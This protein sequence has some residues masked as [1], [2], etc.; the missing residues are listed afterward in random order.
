MADAPLVLPSLPSPAR[1]PTPPLIFIRHPGYG[2]CNGEDILLELPAV[3]YLVVEPSS[4][5][6]TWGLHHGT[7]IIACGIVA[8]N[9]FD[10]IYF[11]Y[12][13]YGQQRVRTPRDGLLKP[14]DYWLQLTGREPPPDVAADSVAHIS[15]TCSPSPAPGDKCYRYPIVPSFQDW[16]FPHG[17]LPYEWQQPHNPPNPP[18]PTDQVANRC[19]LTD[20]QIGVEE[21]HVIPSAQQKWFI[22]NQMRRYCH[23]SAGMKIDD[24]ANMLSLMAHFRVAFDN[25]LFI[26]IPKPSAGSPSS[27]L[28]LSTTI[29]EPTS[30][31][32]PRPYA[33]ATHFL[34]NIPEACDF[35]NLYHNVSIQTKY[36]NT[37]SREFLFA[38]FAWAL[39][40]CLRGFLLEST[41]CRHLVVSEG[42]KVTN[43]W[44]NSQQYKKHLALR[45]ESV[46]TSKRRRGDLNSQNR[47][48]DGEDNAYEERKRH[49][50]RRE[51]V[52]SNYDWGSS[53][54]GRSIHRDTPS[55][56]DADAD[57]DEDL[58]G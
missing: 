49:S 22:Q 28:S 20:L 43:K 17:K 29:A 46:P 26:I 45:G 21:C 40:S 56:P 23:T 25:H 7:A 15:A 11:S 55:E 58:P 48:S 51:S 42:N 38:R 16:Q 52:L 6:R 10:D 33:F 44:M 18:P 27:S 2:E 13:L 53:D 1:N 54:R 5:V 32:E 57:T 19:F 50:A 3:D 39:F 24:K 41:V 9:T 4:Q 36:I 35:A 31:A 12:D 47:L 34:S 8:N 14:G 37:L 30:R